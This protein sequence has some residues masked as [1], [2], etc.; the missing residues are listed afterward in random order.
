MK[1]TVISKLCDQIN[2]VRRVSYPN[3]GYL[4]F[5]DIR[6]DGPRKRRVYCIANDSG[7]VTAVHNGITHRQTAKNLREVLAVQ[8]VF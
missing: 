5:A 8:G 2:T 3:K 6:G 7:G 1:N 4:Y